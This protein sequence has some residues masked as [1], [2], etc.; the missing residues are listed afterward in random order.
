MWVY[1]INGILCCYNSCTTSKPLHY[2]LVADFNIYLT[3]FKSSFMKIE[4][5]A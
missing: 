3:L 5:I 4:I 1:L 2:N